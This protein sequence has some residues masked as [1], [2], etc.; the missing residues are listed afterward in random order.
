[1]SSSYKSDIVFWWYTTPLGRESCGQCPEKCSTVPSLPLFVLSTA[2]G[3]ELRR[4]IK[5]APPPQFLFFICLLGIMLLQSHFLIV[6]NQPS[7]RDQ[8]DSHFLRIFFHCHFSF[9][10]SSHFNF[11]FTSRKR[12]KGFYLSLFPSKKKW[13]LSVFHSFFSRKKGEIRSGL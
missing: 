9:S 4:Q 7:I 2:A 8:W 3:T 1:M 6:S 11:T 5:P 10:I 13:K 12:V